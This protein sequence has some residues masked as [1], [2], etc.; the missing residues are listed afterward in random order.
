MNI[1]L[2]DN[3]IAQLVKEVIQDVMGDNS[4]NFN[5]IT[6]FVDSALSDSVMY[7]D[8]KKQMVL[9]TII[10]G[11]TLNEAFSELGA[12]EKLVRGKILVK[13]LSHFGIQLG[14]A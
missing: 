12:E 14:A 8:P 13:F 10:M 2:T 1:L 9:E 6:R 7:A 11:S 3:E 4:S 5:K